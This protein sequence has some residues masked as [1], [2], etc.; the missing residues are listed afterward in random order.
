MT[1]ASTAN[2]LPRHLNSFDYERANGISTSMDGYIM[3]WFTLFFSLLVLGYVQ[4]AYDLS[5]WLITIL[6]VCLLCVV[7]SIQLIPD[8]HGER[9]LPYEDC[10]P[11]ADY[12]AERVRRDSFNTFKVKRSKKKKAKVAA[13]QH[14]KS[15]PVPEYK[16]AQGGYVSD[17]SNDAWEANSDASYSD[18]DALLP[19]TPPVTRSSNSSS[20]NSNLSN[21]EIDRTAEKEKEYEEEDDGSCYYGDS[22]SLP[23]SIKT[24]RLWGIFYSFLVT[25]GAGLM[26]IY[27]VY[28]I[29]ESVGKSPS[30][31]FVTLIS[32]ANGLGRVTA[33]L[34][35]DHIIDAIQISKLQL[36]CLVVL[37]MSFTQALLSIGTSSLLFPCFLSVGFLFGCTVSLTAINVADIYGEK[38]IAT[39]FGFVDT[40]PI[41]G[42][43]IFAT[44]SIDLFYT[45]N[46]TL[47]DGEEV[48]IGSSCFRYCF[49]LNSLACLIAS[50]L[51]YFMH[52]KTPR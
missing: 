12:D 27:N 14:S 9:L 15:R 16:N 26:V 6:V 47:D 25:C 32:L 4:Y 42:S 37:L 29:A 30:T 48:C 39:N 5:D 18:T 17:G 49:I 11:S 1:G 2:V 38:Y 3:H 45:E 8:S 34:T 7:F 33:G 41:I 50:L 46:T 20:S 13:F 44:F 36:L 51:I 23:E 28:D 35:S 21:Q 31:F 10:V 19:G 24:W 40:S 22:L 52:T 43:Y